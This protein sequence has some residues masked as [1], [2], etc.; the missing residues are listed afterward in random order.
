M[1]RVTAFAP[2]S[3][4]EFIQGV[5]RGEPCLVSCPVNRFSKVTVSAGEPDAFL[6]PKASKMLA[7]VFKALSLPAEDKHRIR[8]TLSSDIPVGKGMASSTA[9]LSAVASAVAAYFEKE[10]TEDALAALCAEV[11]P[12]DNIMYRDLNLFN[13]MTGGTIKR[14]DGRQIDNLK[15]LMIDFAGAV[16]TLSFHAKSSDAADETTANFEEIA[17]AFEKALVSGDRKAVGRAC[18][19]S[20]RANQSLLYKPYLETVIALSERFGGLGVVGGHSGTVLGVLYDEGFDAMSFTEAFKTEVPPEAYEAIM[21]CDV[22]A[23]GVRL[24]TSDSPS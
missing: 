17:G 22:V 16:D 13:Y 1:R 23:G 14:F 11:E 7:L 5:L 12:T 4:G 15:V 19:A 9:D 24:Q 21:R 8:V 2:G 10:L 18:T 3:C 20:V 6:P